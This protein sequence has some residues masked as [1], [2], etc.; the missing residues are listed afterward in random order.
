MIFYSA[1]SLQPNVE[2]RNL[3]ETPFEMMI[4]HH[5]ITDALRN[6]QQNQLQSIDSILLIWHC[7]F[8]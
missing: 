5:P 4:T 6:I 3:D 7:M 8:R 2:A 1:D